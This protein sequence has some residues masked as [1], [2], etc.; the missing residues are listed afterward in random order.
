MKIQ[1]LYRYGLLGALVLLFGHSAYAESE[2]V[3]S[4]SSG[5]YHYGDLL[6]FTLQVREIGDD[7][8]IL[9]ITDESGKSSSPIRLEINGYNT[10]LTSPFPF[11]SQ[12]YPE[13]TYTLRIEYSGM[14]ARTEFVLKDSGRTVIP[15]WIKD[16][17]KLWIGGAIS[18]ETFSTSIGFLIG[19]GIITIPDTA[20]EEGKDVIIPQWVRQNAEWWVLGQISDGEFARGLQH[21]IRA[22]IVVV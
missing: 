4:T 22:G 19:E 18:D 14:E 16:V 15:L 21:L 3:L 11:E 12:T 9:Y 7:F 1:P 20:A 6:T 17:S 5:T 2:P 8:A 10:T 13:G